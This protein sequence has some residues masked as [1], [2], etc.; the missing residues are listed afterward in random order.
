MIEHA[1]DCES[2][3]LGSRPEMDTQDCSWH[4]LGLVSTLI[5]GNKTSFYF[6]VLSNE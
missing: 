6:M 4:L 2:R 5:Y 1:L 3:N